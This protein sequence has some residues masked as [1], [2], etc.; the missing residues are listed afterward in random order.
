MLL[1]AL[2]VASNLGPIPPSD[3][4]PSV[5]LQSMRSQLT[6]LINHHRSQYQLTQ[7]GMDELAQQAAQ[8]HA[9][10]MLAS[11]KMSH[12]D[13]A[14]R[15]PMDRYLALGGKADYYGENV[16]FRSP[17]VVDPELLW[18]VLAKLDE[19]MM[20]ETPPNDAHRRNILSDHYTAVGIGV[21]VG[22]NGVFID[23]DFVGYHPK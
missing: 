22:P 1:I 7:L 18:S 9:E 11:D 12:V 15:T 21:A 19:A 10:S 5:E 17:A 20:A 16:G 8:A 23:E 14:G 6:Q 3:G 13:N 2:L 4:L